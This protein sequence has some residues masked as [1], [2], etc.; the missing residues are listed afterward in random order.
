MAQ[1]AWDRARDLLGKARNQRPDRVEFWISLA[2]LADRR[3]TPGA[4]LSILADAER[5]LGDRV[6][7]SLAR[8]NHWSKRGGPEARKE[9]AKLEQKLGNFSAT[10]K[11]RLLG[12]L[13]EANL[14]IGDNVAANRLIGQLI[15]ERPFD[16]SLRFTQF[17]LALQAGD[18]S[19]MER[20]LE[21]IG[22]TEN[23]LLA[24]SKKGA[25][26][27]GVPRLGC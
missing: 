7:M 19:A 8:A 5:R 2:E 25:L 9:L 3:E 26:S 14:R 1:G 18:L 20:I 15:R 10:D 23:Q 16:L 12:E 4:A 21:G 17:G 24:P 22:T 6:E 11:V 27:G 13:T